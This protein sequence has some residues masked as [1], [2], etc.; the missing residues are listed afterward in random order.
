[1]QTLMFTHT[2]IYKKFMDDPELKKQYQEFVFDVLWQKSKRG[3]GI[4]QQ[5]I[6]I[7]KLAMIIVWFDLHQKG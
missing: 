6:G 2:N 3:V 4:E 7:W 5:I 1:M